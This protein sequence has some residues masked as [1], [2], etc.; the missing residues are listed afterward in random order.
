LL[1]VDE[2]EAAAAGSHRTF[3]EY[4]QALSRLGHVNHIPGIIGAPATFG[5]AGPV[6]HD[7]HEDTVIVATVL[8]V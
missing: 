2:L 5:R 7:A 4:V 3:K 8:N 1:A 6:F